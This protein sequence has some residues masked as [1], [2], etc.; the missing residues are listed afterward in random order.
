MSGKGGKSRDP[1]G[2]RGP[3]KSFV[4]RVVL[5]ILKALDDGS[6]VPGLLCQNCHKEPAKNAYGVIVHESPWTDVSTERYMCGPECLEEH[7]YSTEFNYF[8][9][10]DCD[11]YIRSYSLLSPV[12][13]HYVEEDGE[14]ICLRCHEAGA[15]LT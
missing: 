6:E 11:R 15:K 7:F 1:A 12:E 9:C 5:S 4:N 13:K 10:P 3:G 8:S 2:V 14:K